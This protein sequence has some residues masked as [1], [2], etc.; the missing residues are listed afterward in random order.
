[1]DRPQRGSA[2]VFGGNDAAERAGLNVILGHGIALLGLDVAFLSPVL[3]A[4]IVWLEEL[5]QSQ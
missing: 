1:M 2:W 3:L 5:S 4:A